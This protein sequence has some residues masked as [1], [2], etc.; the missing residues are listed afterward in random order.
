[1]QFIPLEIFVLDTPAR[2]GCLPTFLIVG[3]LG[4]D[5]T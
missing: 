1:M 4:F 3:I 5:L 2:I